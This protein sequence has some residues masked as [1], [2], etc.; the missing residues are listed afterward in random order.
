MVGLQGSETPPG[1]GGVGMHTHLT[2]V[3]YCYTY[4]DP[5]EG[6][7]FAVGREQGGLGLAPPAQMRFKAK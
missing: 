3:P 5:V 7:C 1:G 4:S 6:V 2:F